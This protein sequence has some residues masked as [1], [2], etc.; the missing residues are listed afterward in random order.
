MRYIFFLFLL[1][2]G[3]SSCGKNEEPSANM[4]ISAVK[5][6][7]KNESAAASDAQYDP[8]APDAPQIS[9]KIIKQASLRFANGVPCSHQIG[10]S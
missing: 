1:F 5:L 6:T 7:P 3:F 2:L 10:T 9:Q 4:M 8:A